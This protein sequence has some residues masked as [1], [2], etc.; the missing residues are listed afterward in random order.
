MEL[1]LRGRVRA[2]EHAGRWVLID[3]VGMTPVDPLVVVTSEDL[4]TPAHPSERV[5]WVWPD[6]MTEHIRAWDI[7]WTDVQDDE[8]GARFV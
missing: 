5:E 6:E 2:G 7:E 4:D 8:T 1:G 3:S